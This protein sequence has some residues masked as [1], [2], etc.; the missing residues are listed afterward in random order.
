MPLLARLG[1]LVVV[2]SIVG[3]AATAHAS[4]GRR[5]VI[6]IGSNVGLEHEEDLRFG[7]SDA[8]AFADVMLALGGAA[9]G[10]VY[11]VLNPTKRGVEEALDLAVG[12]ATVDATL[13]LYYSGHG[14]ETQLHVSGETIPREWLR[15]K[16]EAASARLR[17]MFIDACRGVKERGL[18][19]ASAFQVGVVDY[20]GLVIIQSASRGEVAFE[21]QRL[22]GGLFTRHLL[23]GLRGPADGDGDGRVSLDEAYTFA[24]VHTL[25]DSGSTQIP[26]QQLD[27]RG[28]G[29][30]ELTRV[31][32]T[33]ARVTLPMEE[34]ARYTFFRRGSA[35]VFTEAWSSRSGATTVA[36]PSGD[37]LV[38]RRLGE[39]SRMTTFEASEDAVHPL[40]SRE[41]EAVEREVMQQRGG[42]AMGRPHRVE[43]SAGVSVS[44]RSDT[45]GQGE[46]IG[47]DYTWRR[48]ER[49]WAPTVG[50]RL[51]TERFDT[52]LGNRVERVSYQGSLGLE[53]PR[54]RLGPV[55]LHF[56]ASLMGMWT[57]Q[58]K[59]A[60]GAE[61]EKLDFERLG[62]V[63]QLSADTA[64]T[65]AVGLS[66][67]LAMVPSLYL[68]R[69]RSSAEQSD[70]H[71][72]I[73]TVM[74]ATLGVVVGL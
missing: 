51:L 21:S 67:N 14:N 13:I 28:A 17:L 12:R 52:W 27:I 16:L 63:L 69:E 44:P 34:P 33:R 50:V 5:I 37:F 70:T 24:H 48:S 59:R 66:L 20:H 61:R 23:S 8:N 64:L 58:E 60:S 31:A 26:E 72:A 47:L 54:G 10:D 53:S 18:E 40:D 39:E 4:T 2:L 45:A 65:D 46:T 30:L 7:A 55:A 6:A 73:S 22:E 42:T 9:A 15:E 74:L 38:W 35:G 11:R 56:S 62:A 25:L 3:S 57:Q 43:L 36:L 32:N 68:E 1:W 41:F 49:V 29:A 71:V 19:P